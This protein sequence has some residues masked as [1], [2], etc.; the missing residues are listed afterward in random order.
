MSRYFESK[1]RVLLAS[2][3]NHLGVITTSFLPVFLTGCKV[4]LSPFWCN[5]SGFYELIESEKIQIT[6]IFPT[7][8]NSYLQT[9]KAINLSSLELVITG[10][11]FIGNEY[12]NQLKKLGAQKTIAFYGSTEA[13]PPVTVQESFSKTINDCLYVGDIVPHC[14]IRTD[15]EDYLY[16]SGPNICYKKN[17]TLMEEGY[18]FGDDK[19]FVEDNS[20]YLQLR[21]IHIKNQN[22]ELVNIL[23][24]EWN[25]NK[26]FDKQGIN[27]NFTVALFQEKILLCTLSNSESLIPQAISK[28]LE[29]YDLTFDEVL[30]CDKLLFNGIKDQRKL[31]NYKVLNSRN[32]SGVRYLNVKI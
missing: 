4:Y 13:L 22:N 7:G 6:S 2:N 14:S 23:D 12:V 10:G 17:E 20:L 18:V 8:F 9:Q 16:V 25:L 27:H 28:A 31:Q 29:L 30:I 11:Q 32:C 3:L 26:S 5:E 19:G 15:Q 24:V 21:D 1:K